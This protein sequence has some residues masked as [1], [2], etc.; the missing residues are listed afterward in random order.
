MHI[1]KLIF[2]VLIM[3]FTSLLSSCSSTKT[4]DTDFQISYFKA[5]GRQLKKSHFKIEIKGSSVYYNGIANMPI[6]GET[7]FKLSK[8]EFKKIKNA[9]EQADFNKFNK[10]YIGK[11]RDMAVTIITYEGHEVKYQEPEAPDKLK[12]LA[13]LLE[14]CLPKNYQ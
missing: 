10:K 8:T 11:Y 2:G 12:G 6:L 1:N 7:N 3:S 4:N 5:K 14:S 9:F 13:V